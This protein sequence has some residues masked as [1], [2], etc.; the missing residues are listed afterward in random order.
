MGANLFLSDNF[1]HET[2]LRK[3]TGE[4]MICDLKSENQENDSPAAAAEFYQNMCLS[5]ALT[6]P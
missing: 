1:Y 2:R 4:H 6:V 5:G 3:R